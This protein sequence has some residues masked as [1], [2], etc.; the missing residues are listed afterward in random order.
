MVDQKYSWIHTSNPQEVLCE[1]LTQEV[2]L[3]F[4]RGFDPEEKEVIIS[5]PPELF[6][7]W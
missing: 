3:E 4:Y 5:N 7:H 2:D 6:S 1:G